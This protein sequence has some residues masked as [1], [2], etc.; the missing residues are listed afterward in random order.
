MVLRTVIFITVTVLTILF[1]SYAETTEQ[2]SDVESLR[3]K[4]N[5]ISEL[6]S[7]SEE[8]AQK[9]PEDTT[10]QKTQT[11]PVPPITAGQQQ[12]VTLSEKA[13]IDQITISINALYG[14]L[15]ECRK[16]NHVKC[17]TEPIKKERD[18][19]QEKINRLN[20]ELDGL[21]A[22]NNSLSGELEDLKKKY[23]ELKEKYI[24]LQM[25]ATQLKEIAEKL[26]KK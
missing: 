13:M 14:S 25:S 7:F 2:Q 8:P 12:F 21:Q 24:K 11:P 17:D 3:N 15:N 26:L 22:Q 10:H 16:A 9:T 23:A 5:K 1:N 4:L 6:L 18:E 20:K 19:L